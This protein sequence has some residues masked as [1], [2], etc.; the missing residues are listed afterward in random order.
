MSV[1]S[2]ANGELTMENNGDKFFW[3]RDNRRS[4]DFKDKHEACEALKE[5]GKIKWTKLPD[6]E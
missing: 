4:Q 5:R 3:I 2:F 1:K 6:K